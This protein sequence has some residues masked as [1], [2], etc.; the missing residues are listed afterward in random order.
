L[1]IIKEIISKNRI[2]R[3][4]KEFFQLSKMLALLNNSNFKEYLYDSKNEGITNYAYIINI[5]SFLY[6]EIFNKTISSYAIPIRE[7]FQLH[8]EILKNYYKQN[9]HIILNF[10]IRTNECK[11]IFAGNDLYYY[12]NSSF[13]DLFP[14]I[15]KEVLIYDFSNNILN[16][17]ENSHFNKTLLKS[18]KTIK[19]QYTESNLIIKHDYEHI[20]YYWKINLRLTLL[21]NDHIKETVLFNGIYFIDKNILLTFTNK[22][23]REIIC[24]YGN[25][26]IMEFSYKHKLNFNTF[27]ESDFMLN[28][29]ANY[30]YS[31]PVNNNNFNI[32]T[33]KENKSSQKF[34]KLKTKKKK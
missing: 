28:K 6:E 7:N 9:N 16:Y 1:S 26:N 27:K 12:V 15:M 23:G 21:F 2:K 33:L 29:T 18:S 24:G 17:K 10:N 4:I 34:K 30:I 5:C 3:Y 22:L 14:N 13:Y 31:I 25:K 19:K 20:Y 8:E 32:Y 11:I